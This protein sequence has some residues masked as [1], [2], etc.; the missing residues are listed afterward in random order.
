VFDGRLVNLND[1]NRLTFPISLSHD[2]YMILARAAFLKG[3]GRD[4]FIRRC[5][6]DTFV[7]LQREG[8]DLGLVPPVEG[9]NEDRRN[10]ERKEQS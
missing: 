1:G 3:M 9:R 10:K 4:E 8:L 2:E 6:L 7:R 5:L